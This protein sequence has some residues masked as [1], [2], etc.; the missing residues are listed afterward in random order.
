M[1]KK[2][3]KKKSDYPHP[4]QIICI[5]HPVTHQTTKKNIGVQ[6][7][8]PYRIDSFQSESHKT[9]LKSFLREADFIRLR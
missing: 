2:K 8:C 1:K 5:R 6:Q 3:K 4:S 9:V 7:I